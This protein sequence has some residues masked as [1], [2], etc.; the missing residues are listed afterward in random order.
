MV[1]IVHCL[2]NSKPPDYNA[3]TFCLYCKSR[4]TD[5]ILQEIRNQ[6]IGQSNNTDW[7]SCRI[8]RI[9]AS[10]CF[11][12][13]NCNAFF[14]SLV[15]RIM[16]DCCFSRDVTRVCRRKRFS[17]K[18]VADRK[19][20]RRAVPSDAPN[21]AIAKHQ[22]GRRAYFGLAKTRIVLIHSPM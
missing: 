1:Q 6:T 18:D 11:E 19:V 21:S 22:F 12:A 14:G 3:E 8:G 15:E 16:G 4:M 10:L 2:L 20:I 17:L 7:F 5:T 13:S 9:T